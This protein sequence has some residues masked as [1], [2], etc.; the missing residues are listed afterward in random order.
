MTAVP[1][2]DRRS[3]NELR[4]N[5][6]KRTHAAEEGGREADAG[7]EFLADDGDERH[8]P[9]VPPG[10]C[11]QQ[12]QHEAGK[13]PAQGEPPGGQAV[14]I[15][16]LRRSHSGGTAHQRPHDETGNDRR[17]I[18]AALRLLAHPR[19]DGEDRNAQYADQQADGLGCVEIHDVIIPFL[20][21]SGERSRSPVRSFSACQT[22]L[23]CPTVCFTSPHMAERNSITLAVSAFTSASEALRLRS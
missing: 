22:A 2:D 19:D 3:G 10:A 14:V 8:R 7:P 11:E 4:D 23:R 5:I 9:G 21:A 17:G 13:A 16:K 18:A 15:G 6:D 12:R 1:A 20:D